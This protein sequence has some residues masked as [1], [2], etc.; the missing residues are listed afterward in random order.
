MTDKSTQKQNHNSE[1]LPVVSSEFGRSTGK[2]LL[3]GEQE[4][5]RLQTQHDEANSRALM[6]AHLLK[7]RGTA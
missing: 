6:C 1:L 3:A 7:T 2:W 4:T 5:S